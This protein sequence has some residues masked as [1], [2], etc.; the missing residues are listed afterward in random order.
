MPQ[1]CKHMGEFTADVRV[2]HTISDNTSNISAEF[3][4]RCNLCR[5]LMVVDRSVPPV[6]DKVGSTATLVF[7]P[8]IDTCSVQE[9]N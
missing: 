5:D 1:V 9:E 7:V 4:V 8:P 2:H 3:E 6:V